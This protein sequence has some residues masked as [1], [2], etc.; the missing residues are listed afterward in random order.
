MTKKKMKICDFE[1]VG[2][3]IPL[4]LLEVDKLKPNSILKD[5]Q[6]KNYEGFLEYVEK[7]MNTDKK[8]KNL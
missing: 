8:N 7:F 3:S 2:K 1:S 6:F 5:T 4:A